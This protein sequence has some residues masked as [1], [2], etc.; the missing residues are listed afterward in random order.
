MK[1][2]NRIVFLSLAIIVVLFSCDKKFT[3]DAAHRIPL[4]PESPYDY[5]ALPPDT[6]FNPFGVDSIENDMATLG[7]VLFYDTQLSMNNRVS[8]GSCHLQSR[9]FADDKRFSFGFENVL[10][11]RNSPAIINAGLQDGFFWDMREDNLNEMS[12]Q[13]I[14]NHFEMGI[15]QQE[16]MSAK[17][18]ALDYYP[19][20]FEA[21]FDTAEATPERI[22]F[23]L[24]TFLRSIVSVSSKFDKGV[25]TNF[26]NFTE[27]ENLGRELY[28][29]K[30]PCAACHGAENLAGGNSTAENIG[31]EM[32][33]IDNGVEGI[34]PFSGDQRDGWFKTASLR[35]IEFTAPYMHDGR[36]T[37]LEEVL[38]FYNSG[39]QAHPQLSV[40]LRKPSDGGFF[41]LD[42]SPGGDFMPDGTGRQPIRMFMTDAEKKALIAFMKTFSDVSLMHDPK[43]SDPFVVA[44]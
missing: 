7:R 37:T 42:P 18:N 12:V 31:L 44:E 5:N 22:S 1:N 25:G 36:F 35:N 43:F 38:E 17:I 3:Q 8:C 33:Y 6:T 10:T 41:N 11:T 2:T 28:F 14:A 15:E 24:G 26:S 21:A 30:F 39:V 40:M 4:L 20:L 13:P 9:S 23:A 16:Y 29:V 32:D 34:E 19:A 27:E